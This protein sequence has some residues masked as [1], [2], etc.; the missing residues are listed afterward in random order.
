MD[1]ALAAHNAFV[2]EYANGEPVFEGKIGINGKEYTGTSIGNA[3]DIAGFFGQDA[4]EIPNVYFAWQKKGW[5][6]MEIY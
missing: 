3:A 4:K 1:N 5:H 6:R 2:K